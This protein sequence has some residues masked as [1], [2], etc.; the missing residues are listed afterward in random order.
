MRKICPLI[1]INQPANQTCPAE[2]CAWWTSRNCCALLM[3]AEAADNA[4][5]QLEGIVVGDLLEDV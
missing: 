3:L 5:D 1:S 2:D 4:A